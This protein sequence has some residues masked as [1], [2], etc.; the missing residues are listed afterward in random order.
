MEIDI[1]RLRHDLIDYYGSGMMCGIGA[2]SINISV[3]ERASDEV[4]INIALKLGLNLES[5]KIGYGRRR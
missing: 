1:E 5:Y 4:L 3:I 2:F